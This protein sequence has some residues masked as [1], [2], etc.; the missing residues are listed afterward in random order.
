MDYTVSQVVSLI[1]HI[2][3]S[4]QDF[5]NK[6]LSSSQKSH[7]VSSHGYILFLLSKKSM[8]MGELTSVINRDKS[9]TTVLIKKL[10]DEGLVKVQVNPQDTRSR[11]LSLTAKG[12]KMKKLTSSI[13][14]QLLDL[15]YKGFSDEEKE[16]LLKLLKK[17]SENVDWELSS[18]NQSYTEEE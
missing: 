2:H 8:T 15:C 16:N 18:Q 17:M 7:F 9:T 12:K 5:I 4:T 10:K 1:S 6:K 13:S 11:I 14:C 3:T